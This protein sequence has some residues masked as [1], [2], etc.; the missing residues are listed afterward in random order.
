MFGIDWAFGV[1][2]HFLSLSPWHTYNSHIG[3]IVC[4]RLKLRQIKSIANIIWCD[5]MS[6]DVCVCVAFDPWKQKWNAF[7]RPLFHSSHFRFESKKENNVGFPFVTLAIAFSFP[8]SSQPGDRK[9]AMHGSEY[10]V[11]GLFYYWMKFVQTRNSVHGHTARE[12]EE[13]KLELLK[14]NRFILESLSTLCVCI[15][16]RS[17][18][19]PWLWMRYLFGDTI[20]K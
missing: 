10:H 18:T 1:W 7:L 13:K 5:V 2:L 9:S 6:Y 12:E 11:F 16:F 14:F 3:D 19:Q 17:P 15:V 4:G 8:L 20:Y